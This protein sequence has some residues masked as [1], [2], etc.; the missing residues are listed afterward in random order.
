MRLLRRRTRGDFKHGHAHDGLGR[1]EGVRAR[2]VF[3]FG[4]GS[5]E[6]EYEGGESSVEIDGGTAES[7]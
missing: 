2:R 5:G 1:E 3:G 7:L 6:E 4:S